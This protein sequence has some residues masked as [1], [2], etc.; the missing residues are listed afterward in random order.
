MPG[1]LTGRDAELRLDRLAPF[2]SSRLSPDD[3]EGRL[4]HSMTN[5]G[6]SQHG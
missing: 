3:H 4:H 1:Q 2:R 6:M 5:G